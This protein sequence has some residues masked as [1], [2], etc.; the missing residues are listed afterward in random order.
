MAPQQGIAPMTPQQIAQQ[1]DQEFFGGGHDITQLPG[2]A[3]P[4]TRKF[5]KTHKGYDIAT[6]QGTEVDL[7]GFDV[8]GY[9]MDQTG[10]GQQINLYNPKSNQT[11]TISHLSKII[12]QDGKIRAFTGG[13]PGSY[14]AGNTTGQ[15]AD[16]QIRGGNQPQTYSQM[17]QRQKPPTGGAS[18][19]VDA[20][21]LLR[22]VRERYG[23]RII[24]ISSDP[25][26]LKALGRGKVIKITV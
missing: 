20:K 1:L 22:Q 8:R 21:A 14:G 24:G 26:K 23:N 6:P 10:Y 16:I 13:Q 18:S 4:S 19:T 15:H 9:G 7:S 2:A 5:Y 12:D 11:Y 17:V 3:H 25:E